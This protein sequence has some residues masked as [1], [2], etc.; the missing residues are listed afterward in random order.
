MNLSG[1]KKLVCFAGITGA[2]CAL[3]AEGP[4]TGMVTGI[5]YNL[6]DKSVTVTVAAGTMKEMPKP[7]EKKAKKDDKPIPDKMPALEDMITFSGDTMTFTLS[8]DTPLEFDRTTPAPDN[9][10]PGPDGNNK[11]R[12]DRNAGKKELSKNN[13]DRKNEMPA[14]TVKQL[15]IGSLVEVMYDEKGTVV[16]GIKIT[17]PPFRGAPQMKNGDNPPP[18]DDGAPDGGK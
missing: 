16:T 6:T 1:M 7:D 12:K 18:A 5:S 11:T 14:L 13:N 10:G 17:Q 2:L 4:H 9:R 8:G 3:C 15:M